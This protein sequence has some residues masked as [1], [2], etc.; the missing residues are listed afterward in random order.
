MLYPLSYE[1]VPVAYLQGFS[2]DCGRVALPGHMALCYL[3]TEFAPAH[4]CRYGQAASGPVYGWR[5]H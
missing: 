1:G 5:S 2:D 4:V 3:S